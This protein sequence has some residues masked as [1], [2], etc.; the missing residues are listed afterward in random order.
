MIF[1]PELKANGLIKQV[2]NNTRGQAKTSKRGSGGGGESTKDDKADT[3]TDSQLKFGAKKDKTSSQRPDSCGD[4]SN[5]ES[6][7]VFHAKNSDAADNNAS[8]NSMNKRRKMDKPKKR[9]RS[10]EQ[11]DSAGGKKGEAAACCEGESA[12]KALN[13]TRHDTKTRECSPSLSSVE[14]GAGYKKQ[15]SHASKEDNRYDPRNAESLAVSSVITTATSTPVPSAVLTPEDLSMKRPPFATT[16]V[17]EKIASRN[18]IQHSSFSSYVPSNTRNQSLSAS[19]TLSSTNLPTTSSSNFSDRQRA[20]LESNSHSPL[21]LSSQPHEGALYGSGSSVQDLEAAMSRH[22][23]GNSFRPNSSSNEN[24]A[25]TSGFPSSSFTSI[26]P[27]GQTGL[28]QPHSASGIPSLI[29]VGHPSSYHA[30]GTSPTGGSGWLTPPRA[31]GSDVLTASNFLRSLYA[32]STRESVIKTGGGNGRTT[33][34]GATSS[35][36]RAPFI[37]PDLPPSTLLTP[38]E[39]DPITYRAQ[40]RGRDVEEDTYKGIYSYRAPDSFSSQANFHNHQHH[41]LGAKDFEGDSLINRDHAARTKDLFPPSPFLPFKDYPQNYPHHPYLPISDHGFNQGSEYPHQQTQH[42]NIRHHGSHLHQSF[43]NPALLSPPS[44]SSVYRTP[45]A[46]SSVNPP[47]SSSSSPYKDVIPTF[48]IPSLMSPTTPGPV[49]GSGIE[50]SDGGNGRKLHEALNQHSVNFAIAPSQSSHLVQQ[51]QP[52]QPVD[53]LSM[54]PPASASPDPN[55]MPPLS[56]PFASEIGYPGSVA[57]STGRQTTGSNNNLSGFPYQ[58]PYSNSLGKDS[59]DGV[60]K[61]AVYGMGSFMD[62]N[63]LNSGA[64]QYDSCP[65]P[66]LSWY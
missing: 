37:D 25:F 22:L 31:T 23:P 18:I 20:S 30:S 59:S 50:G 57:H 58:H 26:P 63:H 52:P 54:T 19:D 61:G 15:E 53:T 38:P 3:F 27:H 56:T 7:D 55:K 1:F 10:R 62:L 40:S 43:T 42:S 16:E 41:L 4:V 13:L 29:A 2:P 51:Q 44:A 45:D 35:V 11:I 36:S 8:A 49:A 24:A 14:T 64:S 60:I 46:S 12:E 5:D 28:A 32:A 33:S 66:V 65:R 6:E 34:E 9:A 21:L 39:P 47:S 17:N 48:S